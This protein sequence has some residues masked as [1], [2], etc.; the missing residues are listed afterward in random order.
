MMRVGMKF[1]RTTALEGSYNSLFCATSQQA[2][3]E[4]QG[5]YY[6]PVGKMDSKADPWMADRE[7]NK[8]L[9]EASEAVLQR[10]L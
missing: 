4:G 2:F 1:R 6:V 7:G 8:R 10:Y 9:W 5:R 3:Q